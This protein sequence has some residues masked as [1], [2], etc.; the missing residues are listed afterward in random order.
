MKQSELEA[1]EQTA[2]EGKAVSPETV[3][4]LIAEIRLLK[5]ILNDIR[6]ILEDVLENYRNI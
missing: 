5:S 2:K 1:V 4:V 3:L 6:K